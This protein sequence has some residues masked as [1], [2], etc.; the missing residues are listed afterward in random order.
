V[1]WNFDANNC[2]T[3]GHGCLGGTCSA[4]QC[5]GFTIA[6][7]QGAP[8]GITLAN[9]DYVYF[10]CPRSQ[11]IR[12]VHK[13]GISAGAIETIA[14]NRSNWPLDIVFA[15][16]YLYFG[17]GPYIYQLKP[18]GSELPTT[19]YSNGRGGGNVIKIATDYGDTSIADSAVRLLWGDPTYV[20]D[21]IPATGPTTN[22]YWLDQGTAGDPDGVAVDKDFFIWTH[23][24]SGANDGYVLVQNRNGGSGP[25][26]AQNQ[27]Q[28]VAVA[29][30]GDSAYW[31]NEGTQGSSGITANTGSIYRSKFIVGTSTWDTPTPVIQNIA[32]PWHLIV[33]DQWVYWTSYVA[34]TVSKVAKSGGSAVPLATGEVAPWYL[35]QDSVSIYWTNSVNNGDVKRLAK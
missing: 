9:D 5:Q 24:G 23:L 20:L 8:T 33:D 31:A 7:L 13:A 18:D 19:W 10:T 2:G 22:G 32:Q 6:P 17:E 27:P 21:A 29:F 14:N 26:I 16:G 1:N 34:G 4:G 30:D 12:R 15:I 11:L 28:P 25:P 3:C 35:A